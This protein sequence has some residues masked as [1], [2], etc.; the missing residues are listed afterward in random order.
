MLYYSGWTNPFQIKFANQAHAHSAIPFVQIEP[1]GISMA[2]IAAGKYDAYL[3]SYA[4]AVRTYG[5]H[6]I[7]SFAPEAIGRWYS[8][9]W[10][11]AAPSAWKAAWR[12][13]VTVF[14]RAGA[15]NVTWLWTIDRIGGRQAPLSD[16]W[17]GARYVN[18]IGIDGYYERPADTFTSVFGS[19]LRAIRKLT[20]DP[21]LLSETAVGPAAGQSAKI[22]QLFAGVRRYH[23]MGL[24]WFDKAQHHGIYHQDWRLDGNPAGLAAFR[25]GTA[26]MKSGARSASRRA[27]GGA[28]FRPT[29]RTRDGDFNWLP[30]EIEVAALVAPATASTRVRDDSA[31]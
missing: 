12:H 2:A 4:A 18:W 21:V 25:R 17:P 14:R 15:A 26:G 6:I 3:R 29:R 28:R 31:L 16:Y 11:H 7:L 8:W 9:G 5:Y 1:I 20:S 10:T 27:R 19:T 13:V 22:P 30:A 24:V 23:L